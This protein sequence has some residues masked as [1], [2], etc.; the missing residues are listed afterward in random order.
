M[1]S[2]LPEYVVEE[3]ELMFIKYFA[4]SPSVTY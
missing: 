3:N 1:V 4:K 2:N